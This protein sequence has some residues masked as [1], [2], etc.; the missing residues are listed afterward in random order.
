MGPAWFKI[1]R[2]GR[3]FEEWDSMTQQTQI[4]VFGGGCFWCTEAIFERI[5]GVISVMPGYAGGEFEN[6]TYGDVCAGTTGHAE[7][8]RVEFDPAQ[9]S[10]RDLLTVFFST[11][12]PTTLNRQGHDV[13][14]QYRSIILYAGETQHQ[15]AKTFIADLNRSGAFGRPVVTEL[16]QLSAFYEAEPYHRRYYSSNSG[17]PYCSI[18]ITPKLEKLKSHFRQML[19]PQGTAVQ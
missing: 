4:A 14:S 6:P 3:N 2:E 19:K 11:H 12:D 1:E 15:E 9:V 18:V 13:G 7:V 10:Y 17:Q 16:K 8:I 5:T